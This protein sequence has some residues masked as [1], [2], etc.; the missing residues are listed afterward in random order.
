MDHACGLNSCIYPSAIATKWYR[1]KF[2][3]KSDFAELSHEIKSL[4]AV[5]IFL[6]RIVA[7]AG[8][9]QLCRQVEEE[10][11][12]LLALTWGSEGDIPGSRALKAEDK[13][14]GCQGTWKEAEAA[15]CPGG[16]RTP[17][18]RRLPWAPRL[19][20]LCTHSLRLSQQWNWT[21]VGEA[22]VRMQGWW[23]CLPLVCLTV[24]L[25]HSKCLEDSQVFNH[26]I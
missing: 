14:D 18:T 2:F 21:L 23:L 13:R 11:V 25:H 26:E 3:K 16:A 4:A 24:S 17:V 19:R 22:S 15:G 1:V 7:R 5:I 8:E 12:H 9:C 10:C 6:S 20:A